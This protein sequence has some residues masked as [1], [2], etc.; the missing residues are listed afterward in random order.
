MTNRDYVAFLGWR[1]V[2]RIPLVAARAWLE[3]HPD[4]RVS[5]K[6]ELIMQ[7][8]GSHIVV[9]AVPCGPDRELVTALYRNDYAI[10][11]IERE[12]EREQ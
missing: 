4:S 1:Q 11:V 12:R 5:R 9:D 2:A 7:V 6:A 8:N 10:W 3:H